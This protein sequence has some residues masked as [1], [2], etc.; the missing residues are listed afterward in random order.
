M[1]SAVRRTRLIFASEVIAVTL[2]TLVLVAACGSFPL[3]HATTPPTKKATQ[4]AA[5]MGKAFTYQVG[6]QQLSPFGEP[7]HAD[8]T[9]GYLGHRTLE[10]AIYYPLAQG[11]AS[12]QPAPGRLPLL[13]FAPGFQYCSDTY[14][15]LLRT[16][17]SAGYV[18]AAVNFP[19]TECNL[20]TAADELDV[21]NQPQDMSYVLSKLLSLSAQPGNPLSGL[22]NPN[23][24]AA[25]GHSDGGDTVA[26]LGASTCCTDAHTRLELKAVAVLSGAALST[27]TPTFPGPG[28]YFSHGAPPMMF[29]QGS[30]DT[31]SPPSYSRQLYQA[32]GASARYYFDLCGADHWKPY[33]GSNPTE[34]LVARVT[35]D[36]F[37]RYVL[38]R[39]GAQ[40]TMMRHGNVSGIAALV[41]GGKLPPGTCLRLTQ[42][43]LPGD[44]AAGFD[45][46]RW[47]VRCP[48]NRTGSWPARVSPI[49]ATAARVGAMT[50][51]VAA[52]RIYQTLLA[53]MSAGQGR[54]AL[55]RS[56][57]WVRRMGC[58]RW[59]GPQL[60]RSSMR[61]RRQLRTR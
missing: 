16:W 45:K 47:P 59:I 3:G 55:W 21:V 42:G 10:T 26:A 60:L 1:I 33:A 12:P 19:R 9:G 37:D 5:P 56:L 8:P 28:T 25:V 7:A 30:A 53:R 27:I 35:L 39:D 15:Y 13:L 22:L 11:S 61:D 6:E 29:V 24:V 57:I 49:W 17:A 2:A 48:A 32:D 23:Q 4:P 51:A 38:G 34:Q 40:P 58:R 54:D 14:K 36:F 50:L 41:R 31:I 43:E 46:G 20:G 44:G 18:V 52:R